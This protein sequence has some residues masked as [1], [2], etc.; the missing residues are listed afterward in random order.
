M[1]KTIKGNSTTCYRGAIEH[2]DDY[3][4]IFKKYFR[5][6]ANHH[7]VHH[8]INKD[9][10]LIYSYFPMDIS[11]RGCVHEG[12]EYRIPISSS[13]ALSSVFYE[14]KPR[15]L[16]CHGVDRI[17]YGDNCVGYYCSKNNVFCCGDISHDAD[18][19][20]HILAVL[21]GMVGIGLLH[22]L[23]KDGTRHSITLGAD[24]EMETKI[25]GDLVSAFE[26]P[27]VCTRNKA[28]ISHDGHTQ[29]QRELRPDP[30]SS[31]EELVENIRDLIKIS[32]FFNEELSVVGSVLPLG[33]HI[34][35]GNAAPNKELIDVLDYFLFPFNEFNSVERK[36]SKYGKLGDVRQQPHGFEYRT[37]PAAWLLTPTMA[38][39]T[40]E[41]TQNIVEKII[42]DED[43]E[44]SDNYNLEEY[45]ENLGLLGFHESWIV[46]F[47]Q[48]I[49]WAK[50]HINEPLAKTW[51]VEIPKEY[52]IKKV[53]REIYNPPPPVQPIRSQPR[54]VLAEEL[55]ALSVSEPE[56]EEEEHHDEDE[57]YL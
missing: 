16:E 39:M 47:I 3:M 52:R 5:S 48:E 41:L 6:I 9:A 54:M 2:L 50:T 34:H 37:P 10:I 26:L 19:E 33:G 30:S 24:P 12:E 40:L 32:S 21:E 28:Y 31:P 56:E 27:Q 18:Q 29:P 49:D 14:K 46:Q 1:R 11:C 25:N 45:K 15:D 51:D 42:N 22:P 57:G 4:D 8:A 43:V 35:I 17:L 36:G 53:Y 23:K 44:I 20:V 7:H 38:R 55:E 13:R